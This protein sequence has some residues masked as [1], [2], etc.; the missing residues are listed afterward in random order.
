MLRAQRDVN[1]SKI[2]GVDVGF[3][4]I[5]CRLPAVELGLHVFHR[6]VRALH[7]ANLDRP[8]AFTVSTLGEGDDLIQRRV[9]LGEVRL[10]HD[11]G[12]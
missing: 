4:T 1:Q 10:Q 5:R 3:G 7:Q 6:Q 11:A 8:A 2:T 9:G 12:V